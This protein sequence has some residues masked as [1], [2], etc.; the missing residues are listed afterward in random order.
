QPAG[1]LVQ[2][3]DGAAAEAGGLDV[4]IRSREGHLQLAVGRRQRE[5]RQRD[6]GRGGAAGERRGCAHPCGRRGGGELGAPLPPLPPPSG[7][8]GPRKPSWRCP[9]R[10]ATSPSEM[11]RLKRPP[12]IESTLS[13]RWLPQAPSLAAATVSWVAPPML[14]SSKV[15]A[16]RGLPE[17][18]RTTQAS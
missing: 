12:P 11:V 9:A 15:V 14:S 5:D 1:R 3:G 7:T 17:A 13:R 2:R 18:T 4:G 10:V 16:A 8:A 6:V